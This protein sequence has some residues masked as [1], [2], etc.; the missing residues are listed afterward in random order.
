MTPIRVLLVD[1]SSEFLEAVARFLSSDGRIEL[2]GSTYSG[3]EVLQK[4][5]DVKPDLI[6]LDIAMPDMNGLE[7]TR[8]IKAQP[9]APRVIIL[10]LYDNSEYRSAAGAVQA[11]GFVAKSELGEQLL[12]L[13]HSLSYQQDPT[14]KKSGQHR[15]ALP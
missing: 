14:R 10:T 4:V 1:D 6:L 13:I 5:P 15:K 12:P 2:I 9:G 8:R 11:D 3:Q 7:L